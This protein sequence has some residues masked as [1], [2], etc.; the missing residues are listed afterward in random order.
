MAAREKQ[1]LLKKSA[2]AHLQSAEDHADKL[3]GCLKAVCSV[4]GLD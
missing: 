3:E 1:L 2:A 4:D